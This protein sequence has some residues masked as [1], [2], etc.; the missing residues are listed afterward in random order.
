MNKLSRSV[1]WSLDGESNMKE[2]R[3]TTRKDLKYDECNRDDIGE[4]ANLVFWFV[5]YRIYVG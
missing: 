4:L 1:G 2:T 3:E 5:K